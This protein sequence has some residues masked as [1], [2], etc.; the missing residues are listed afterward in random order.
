MEKSQ[1]IHL[2]TTTEKWRI[3]NNE[4]QP[5]QKT[6]SQHT[7]Y[8]TVKSSQDTTQTIRIFP[9]QTT[10]YWFLGWN[11]L[12]RFSLKGTLDAI[13][14]NR[15]IPIPPLVMLGSDLDMYDIEVETDGDDF[16]QVFTPKSRKLLFTHFTPDYQLGHFGAIQQNLF[17][18]L[19]YYEVDIPLK[20]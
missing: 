13:Q 7:L 8:Y 11:G 14:E 6:N 15:D 4:I 1:K 17:S 3:E 2:F 20:K 10:W 16:T 5:P 19:P 12:E 18:L 9:V